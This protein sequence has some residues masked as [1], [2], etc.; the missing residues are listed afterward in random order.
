MKYRRFL[1]FTIGMFAILLNHVPISSIEIEGYVVYGGDDNG[2]NGWCD[3]T[4]VLNDIAVNMTSIDE[5]YGMISMKDVIKAFD[6]VLGK[7]IYR[8]R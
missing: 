5:N 3:D 7:K 1:S 4:V 2:V 6:E 8:I